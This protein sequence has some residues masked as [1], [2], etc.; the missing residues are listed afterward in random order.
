MS[1][2]A[3]FGWLYLHLPARKKKIYVDTS[4]L[5]PKSRGIGLSGHIL[6]IARSIAK[7]CSAYL[8]SRIAEKIKSGAIWIRSAC[9]GERRNRRYPITAILSI[10][11]L[12]LKGK[13]RT[14]RLF[15]YL[16]TG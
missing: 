16:T 3:K 14:D 4:A 2:A 11:A 12:K 10:G 6:E 1:I 15:G 9:A 8:T 5:K 7:P 13:L